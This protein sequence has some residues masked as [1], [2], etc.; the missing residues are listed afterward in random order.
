MG[1]TPS[2]SPEF[3]LTPQDETA[4]CITPEQYVEVEQL[5][6]DH[7]RQL[8][9][10]GRL[11]ENYN[12][13]MAPPAFIWPVRQATG[14]NYPSYYSINN[15]VDLDPNPGSVLDWNCGVRTYDGHRGI[16][17]NN[18]PF[19]WNM[20]DN[21]QVEAIAAADGV[22]IAKID[23]NPDRNCSCIEPWNVIMIEH[24][25][26]YQSWYAH[27]KSGSQT[28]KGVGE[29]VVA[30]E[31]LGVIG[32]AG[33]SSNPHL[34]FEVR[35]PESNFVEP[36]VGSCNSLA[37]GSLWADQKPYREGTL[38]QLLTHSA[39]P[40]VQFCPEG[41][42]TNFQ[43]QFTPGDGAY[44]A[45]YYHDQQNGEQTSF[46]ILDPNGTT[47]Y[48]WNH[49]SPSSY[50]GSWWYWR[51]FIPTDG[52]L[53]TWQFIADY[54]GQQHT[55]YFTVVCKQELT[56][57]PV[58]INDSRIY[59]VVKSISTNGAVAITATGEVSMTAGES[60]LLT[61]G[62]SVAPGGQLLAVIDDCPFP[63]AAAEPEFSQPNELPASPFNRNPLTDQT[64]TNRDH[65]KFG[66]YPNPAGDNFQVIYE[67]IPTDEAVTIEIYE[68]NGR[69]LQRHAYT[70][71]GTGPQSLP[72]SSRDLASGQVYLIRLQTANATSVRR[73]VISR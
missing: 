4:V 28:T 51:W 25:D 35:D 69:L 70:S 32:S 49:T 50:N 45:A 38:N 71:T 60:I 41:E 34:H 68:L 58:T 44:F 43:N 52:A 67:G 7:R 14:F 13:R 57:Q 73:L 33:C 53:G 15:F 11:P 1:L 3:Q 55:H 23:G 10:T 21:D 17:I 54:N 29:S 12:G 27:L 62:F 8:I 22:I 42:V 48:N 6:Q 59:S 9:R 24:E 56:I 72:F 37:T 36:Y 5:M 16:D 65:L 64:L 26:G 40:S 47:I 63:A 2:T 19:W 46:Q 30:G 61:P 66:I 31:Y 20:M 39:P 18:W